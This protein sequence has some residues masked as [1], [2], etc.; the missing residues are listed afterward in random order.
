MPVAY[1][2]DLQWR[3]VWHYL[4]KEANLAEIAESLYVSERMVQW[5]VHLFLV[6][7]NVTAGASV[8]R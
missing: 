5:I 4:Y 2:E 7:G 8:G 3:I 6:T 1:S